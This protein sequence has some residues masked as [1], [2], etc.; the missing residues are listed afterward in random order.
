M[1]PTSDQLRE[2]Y[3]IGHE[4]TAQLKC[5]LRLIELLSG[6]E[7]TPYATFLKPTNLE[8]LSNLRLAMEAE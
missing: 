6:G 7:L 1:E 3:L 2:L 8:T 4:L 5:Y